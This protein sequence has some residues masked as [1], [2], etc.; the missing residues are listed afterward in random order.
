[1]I[2]SKLFVSCREDSCYFRGSLRSHLIGSYFVHRRTEDCVTCSLGSDDESKTSVGLLIHI[3]RLL[4]LYLSFCKVLPQIL[5]R[6]TLFIST[7]TSPTQ[8]ISTFQ[9]DPA[10]RIQRPAIRVAVARSD[11]IIPSLVPVVY[12]MSTQNSASMR[13]LRLREKLCDNGDAPMNRH[14]VRQREKIDPHPDGFPDC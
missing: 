1:M 8:S 5:G 10:G 11:A 4:D 14:L 9:S 13:Q 7:I 3:C 2:G 12:R 6:C